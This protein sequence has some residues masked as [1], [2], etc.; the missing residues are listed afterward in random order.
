LA[1]QSLIYAETNEAIEVLKKCGFR[2]EPN[3]KEKCIKSIHSRIKTDEVRL[4]LKVKE[5]ED[6]MKKHKTESPKVKESDYTIS[7]INISKYRGMNGIL[8]ASEITVQEYAIMLNEYN[9]YCDN[10]EKENHGRK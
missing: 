9:A 5:L 3:N 8:R 10:L 4:E 6:Y 7:L 1:L 2:F